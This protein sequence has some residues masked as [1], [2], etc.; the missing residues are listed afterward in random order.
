MKDLHDIPLPKVIFLTG[1]DDAAKR[2]FS[3]AL[4]DLRPD[5]M[6]LGFAEPLR[7][8]TLGMFFQGD[9]LLD[10]AGLNVILPTGD[11][12]KA[13]Q[14]K[15]WRYLCHEY[16]EGVLGKIMA[17]RIADSKEYFDAFIFEDCTPDTKPDE[18]EIM[19]LVG[20]QNCLYLTVQP[21]FSVEQFLDSHNPQTA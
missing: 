17:G 16:G 5:C 9:P 11:T 21:D 13:F 10:L 12:T 3:T 4:C 6:A 20:A 14:F 8:A 15:L 19:K 7:G 2:A 18:Q 1:E